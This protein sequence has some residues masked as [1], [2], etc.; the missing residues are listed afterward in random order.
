MTCAATKTAPRSIVGKFSI[1]ESDNLQILRTECGFHNVD[2]NVDNMLQQDVTASGECRWQAISLE[3]RPDIIEAALRQPEGHFGAKQ[4]LAW[5]A[6][7]VHTAKPGIHRAVALRC[8]ITN[9]EGGEPYFLTINRKNNGL[10]TIGLTSRRVLPL[11]D[12]TYY[13]HTW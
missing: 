8:S 5:E 6:R 9:G 12:D 4:L 1:F 2:R 10:V 13:L 7:A 11:L 3:G